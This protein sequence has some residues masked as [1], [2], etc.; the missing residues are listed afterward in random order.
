MSCKSTTTSRVARALMEFDLIPKPWAGVMLSF[1]RREPCY[2]TLGSCPYARGGS[3]SYLLSSQ[4]ES[5]YIPLS[6]SNSLSK[7]SC[8]RR[9]LDEFM[10]LSPISS[11]TPAAGLLRMWADD[12]FFLSVISA[13]PS[14][15]GGVA[16]R[17]LAG[18][19]DHTR[20]AIPSRGA[21]TPSR[22]L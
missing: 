20:N 10:M 17:P 19:E 12:L 14:A 1:Q 5:N 15:W 18:A 8:S 21:R 13:Q 11:P 2:D 4:S 22:T 6:A 3:R 9:S 16:V 7:E